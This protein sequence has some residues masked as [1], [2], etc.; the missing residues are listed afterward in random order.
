M[1]SADRI[2]LISKFAFMCNACGKRSK[3]FLVGSERTK[4][5]KQ[6]KCLPVKVKEWTRDKAIILAGV[7]AGKTRAEIGMELIHASNR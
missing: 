4:A 5:I 7:K 2:K 1:T 3:W 6:H